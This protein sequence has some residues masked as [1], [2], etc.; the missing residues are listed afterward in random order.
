MT[1]FRI[2]GILGGLSLVFFSII[3]GHTQTVSGQ[4]LDVSTKE[5]IVGATVKLQNIKETEIVKYQPSDNDGRF[6]FTGLTHAYYK[7]QITSLGYKPFQKFVRVSSEEVGVGKI[8]MSEDSKVLDEIEVVGKVVPVEQKGDTMQI[9]ALAF[10][11]NPDATA[12]DLI[13]KMPGIVVDKSG[14]QAQ[15]E[16]VKKVLVDGREFFGNDPSAAL[17][18]LPSEI[19]DKIQVFDRLSDQAQF[20]GFDDGNTTK[21]INIVTKKTM[22]DGKF[23]RIYGGYG[24]DQL[25]SSGGNINYFNK[26]QRISVIGMA[27]NVNQQ[28]FASEDILGVASGQQRRG[29]GF[30]GGGRSSGRGGRPGGFQRN[31]VGTG[32]VNDFITG[33]QDGIA[34]TQASGINYADAWGKRLTMN[35]SYFF[36]HSNRNNTEL[37]SRQT[38][39]NNSSTQLYNESNVSTSSN[40]N[41]RANLR[42]EYK[43]NPTNII[44]FTPQVSFQNNSSTDQLKGITTSSEGSS[45][46][47]V[48]NS[49]LTDANGNNLSG[50]VLYRHAFEKKGR[51][52]TINIRGASNKNYSDDQLNTVNTSYRGTLIGLDSINQLVPLAGNGNTVSGSLTYSEPLG[53]QVQI[54]T[55]YSISK[56]NSDANK[57]TFDYD[58]FDETV[59]SLDTLL[60]NVFSSNY[61]THRPNVGVTFRNQKYFF[62]GS[63]TYQHASLISDQEFPDLGKTDKR[64]ENLLPFGIFRYNISRTKNIRLI[65]R[66]STDAPST[67]QLQNV[68]DI[69]DPQFFSGG[70][71]NLNQSKN[72]MFI[73]RFSHTVPDKSRTFFTFLMLRNTQ[74]YITN[75]TFVASKDS[76]IEN[77]LLLKRGSQFTKPINIDGYWN[78]RSFSSIGVPAQWLKSNVNLNFGITYT[79]E[80]GL[81]NNDENIANTLSLNGGIV[82]GSNISE[83]MDFNFSYSADY[84][85]VKYTLQANQN[86]TY[87]SHQI[88]AKLNLIIWNNIVFRTDYQYQTFNGLSVGSNDNYSLWNVSLA[89]KFLKDRSA[90]LMFYVFDILGQNSSITRT[91]G[92][93]YIEEVRAQ[94]LKQ[95][96]MFTFTYTLRNFKN[97]DQ[98]D[99]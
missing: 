52:F 26:D 1:F 4:I 72:N 73:T 65:Y 42:M 11:T 39:F 34:S 43:I 17:K 25:Y 88:G 90:E 14:V 7:L 81:V 79:R 19:I 21:T 93:T 96:F 30:G 62:R 99:H 20:S 31:A 60:S 76:I 63:L 66:S 6:R 5:P 47:D 87:I 45:I 68:V 77:G 55:G 40:T 16:D 41:H 59:N 91:N 9:N 44:L 82:V 80:P 86:N 28:N 18:N 27:N 69:S 83:N 85:Q 71:P 57:R 61:V 24:S 67:T 92:E 13:S 78:V 51:T 46:A 53:K 8:L 15:G 37:L 70:N 64:F 97:P 74:D 98:V 33:Q 75:A 50:N 58:P 32:N 48:L 2:F 89:K 10:K 49:Y 38:I 3:P 56:T 54:Q 29:R 36:N 12:E 23:G 35:G 84:S 94:V 95:Y 22:R